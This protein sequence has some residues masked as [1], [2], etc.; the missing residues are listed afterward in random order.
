MNKIKK[1]LL[2]L[3]IIV[4]TFSARAK[5]KGAAKHNADCSDTFNLRDSRLK[6]GRHIDSCH[7]TIEST[8]FS[9]T[10]SDKVMTRK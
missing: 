5:E 3:A 2:Q 1:F 10:K 9:I 7:L 8:C 6:A 4:A